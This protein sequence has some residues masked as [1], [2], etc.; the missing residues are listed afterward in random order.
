M[1]AFART[2]VGARSKVKGNCHITHFDYYN[3]FRLSE[4]NL[5]HWLLQHLITVIILTCGHRY[6]KGQQVIKVS[7]PQRSKVNFE[8]KVNQ[9]ITCTCI[10]LLWHLSVKLDGH[11]YRQTDRTDTQTNGQIHKVKGQKTTYMGGLE[12]PALL[13][14]FD[15]HLFLG[16]ER[17]LVGRHLEV[18]MALLEQS[19]GF[20]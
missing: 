20:L 19:H 5:L 3:L 18:W 10:G 14:F 12:E 11:T 2:V 1:L 6:V 4:R 16:E 17:F 8:I 9:Y 7:I 13:A 15:S